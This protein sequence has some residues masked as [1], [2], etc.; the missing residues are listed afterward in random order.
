MAKIVSVVVDEAWDT[1]SI[2]AVQNIMRAFKYFII[3]SNVL[4]E[5]EHWNES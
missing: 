1:L 5:I 3:F 2:Q 4:P